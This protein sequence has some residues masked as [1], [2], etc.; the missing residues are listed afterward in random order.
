MILEQLYLKIGN[1]VVISQWNINKMSK[2]KLFD[3]F[4]LDG[5]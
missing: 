4:K 1:I 5:T 2:W 3:D